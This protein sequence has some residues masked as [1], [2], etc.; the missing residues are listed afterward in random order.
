[1][2]SGTENVA[3]PSVSCILGYRVSDQRQWPCTEWPWQHISRSKARPRLDMG[4]VWSLLRVYWYFIAQFPSPSKFITRYICRQCCER[5]KS[6]RA[7]HQHRAAARTR[8]FTPTSVH[9]RRA[10]AGPCIASRRDRHMWPLL[11]RCLLPGL[12][13]YDNH[14]WV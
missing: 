7:K 3:G 1:M 4:A 8:G 13:G 14:D 6:G 5:P 9:A 2:P 10:C 11:F 12:K